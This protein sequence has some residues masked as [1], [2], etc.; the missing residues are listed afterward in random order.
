MI[1]LVLSGKIIFLFPENLIFF[2][3]WKM[4][5]DLSQKNTSKYNIFFKCPEKMVFPKKIELQYDLFCIIWKDGIFSW[6]IWY[7]FFGWKME[8]DLSQEKLGNMTFSVYLYKYYKYDI[9][10]LQKIKDELPKKYKRWLL[11][12]F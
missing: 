10:L 1:F 6:K 12:A 11:I 3:R 7:F 4:T 2:F 8:N 5:N 9:T